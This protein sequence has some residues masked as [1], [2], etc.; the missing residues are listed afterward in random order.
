MADDTERDHAGAS[1]SRWWLTPGSASS[2]PDAR[3]SPPVLIRPRRPRV[4]IDDGTRRAITSS[5]R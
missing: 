3:Q 5:F 4:P 2:R 1:R